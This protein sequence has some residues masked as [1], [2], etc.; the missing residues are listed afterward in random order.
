MSRSGVTVTFMD[1]VENYKEIRAASM[2]KKPKEPEPWM[3]EQ[4]NVQQQMKDYVDFGDGY[5]RATV[6]PDG[7]VMNEIMT[8]ASDSKVIKNGVNHLGLYVHDEEEGIDEEGTGG[9]T[10]EGIAPAPKSEVYSSQTTPQV[11][12]DMER[13]EKKAKKKKKKKQKKKN[14]VSLPKEV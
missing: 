5:S 4:N 13:A 7:S 12:E 9:N 11:S 14:K 6:D 3:I 1:F 2:S 10:F 8:E